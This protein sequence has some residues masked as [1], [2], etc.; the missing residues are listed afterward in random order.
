M[1]SHF[2]KRNLHFMMVASWEKLWLLRTK[3]AWKA[4]ERMA[5]AAASLFQQARM[6]CAFLVLESSDLNVSFLVTAS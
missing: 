5:L 4:A 1:P 2:T 6:A 3:C